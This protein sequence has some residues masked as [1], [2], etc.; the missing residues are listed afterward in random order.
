[1]LVDIVS[2]NGCLQLS[3]PVRGD[4][5]IDEDEVACVEGSASGWR[6]TAKAS[7]PHAR[8]KCTAKDRRRSRQ[9][10]ARGQFGGARDVRAYTDEDYRF[11]VKGD[12]VYAFMMGWP[13]NGKA[14]IKSISQGS[15]NFPREVAKVELLGAG[16]PLQFTR[17]ANGLVVSLPAQKPNEY[18]YALKVTPK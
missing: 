9:N 4:G 8:G 11:T 5:T 2:K 3:V 12:V 15:E 6:P 13:E 16:G 7:S 18:A 14:T 1:M 17:D 10:Q